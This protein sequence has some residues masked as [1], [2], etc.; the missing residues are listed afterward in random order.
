[1]VRMKIGKKG[2]TKEIEVPNSEGIRTLEEKENYKNL[3][4]LAADMI[5]SKRDERKSKK[6]DLIMNK[7]MSWS[8]IL[9]Q[10]SLQRNKYLDSSPFKILRTRQELGQI[11]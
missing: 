1:M 9:Q 7:K 8:Q 5:K 11:D 6:G 3:E 2:T 4:I 10:K